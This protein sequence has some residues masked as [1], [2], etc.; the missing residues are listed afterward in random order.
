L[1]SA[2]ETNPFPTRRVILVSIAAS[3]TTMALKFGAYFLT[4]S[5]S[6]LSD[7][8]ESSVNLVAALVAFGALT[9]AARPADRSHAYGHDK[10]E[11]FSSGV[12]GALILVAAA[13]II[14]TAII[15]FL[16]PSPLTDLGPGLVIALVA[17]GI[18]F[19]VSRF[20]L[21]MAKKYD[22]IT[23]EAD[24]H[25]LMTDVWTSAGVIA[26][27]GVVMFAPPSWS[28]L[29]PIIAVVVGLN[30]IRTGVN[31]IG[32]SI[33]G[34]MDSSLPAGEVAQ[35]E[36]VIRAKEGP[37]AIFHGLRTRKSAS[38][39]F[40]DFHLLVPGAIT[41]Q[42]GHDRCKAIEAEICSRLPNTLV[43]IHVEP[44]EDGDA[45]EKEQVGDRADVAQVLGHTDPPKP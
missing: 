23:L 42:A 24:A 14:Y 28:I 20:M 4:G 39:R 36:A 1:T 32:R 21:R 5:V 43:T 8:A 15:R 12:E 19:G 29:D 38:R 45:W 31:L 27:L 3:I 44:Q 11:Y 6:L 33:A 17:S 35:I 34:L 7:A 40:V 30:I 13:T 25:H 41:V 22:S 26:A 37:D 10:A 2:H 9:V 16:H 18:N